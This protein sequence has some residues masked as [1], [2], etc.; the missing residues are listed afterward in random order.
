MSVMNEEDR[1]TILL[2]QHYLGQYPRPSEPVRS[3][4]TDVEYRKPQ[5]LLQAAFKYAPISGRLNIAK[6]IIDANQNAQSQV[7][8]FN[9]RME[10]LSDQI[11]YNLL[12]LS[13]FP[14]LSLIL[15]IVKAQGGRTLS[16]QSSSLSSGFEI[17]AD[18]LELVKKR[19]DCR[20]NVI[21][22]GTKLISGFE[23]MQLH[24]SDDRMER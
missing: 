22:V 9:S 3:Y 24:L 12:L 15:I 11:F 13:P 23:T 14:Q 4:P 1:Y 5:K 18:G 17:P 19:K 2:A 21:S 16:I 8:A 20:T 6:T 7:Q 10:E